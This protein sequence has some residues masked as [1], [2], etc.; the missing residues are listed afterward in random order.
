M[1][2]LNH[3]ARLILE[4]PLLT[5]TQIARRLGYAE[6]KTVYYWINKAHYS[7][8]TAFKRA[9]LEGHFRPIWN[10]GAAESP[11]GYRRPIPIVDE[12][13]AR[14]EPIH[15]ADR[16]LFGHATPGVLFAWRYPGKQVA[17]FLP[18]DLLLAAPIDLPQ[19][20]WWAIA[21]TDR[22]QAVL[23]LFLRHGDATLL[24]DPATHTPDA[25]ARVGFRL[26]QLYRRL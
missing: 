13:T 23:R 8:L 26:C 21:F 6:E 12:F 16:L 7:G 22:H 1:D 9:V 24:I 4:D 18:G 11:A 14:G 3:I 25:A 19:D 20:R 17:H 2:V 10:Q 15:T 5:A